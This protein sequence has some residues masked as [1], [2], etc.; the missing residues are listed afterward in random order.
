M[1]TYDL[2]I[3]E[4]RWETIFSDFSFILN[5]VVAAISETLQPDFGKAHLHLEILLTNDATIQELNKEWRG[6]DKPTNVLS[7]PLHPALIKMVPEERKL[8][9]QQRPLWLGDVVVALETLEH[10][11]QTE[12]KAIKDHF[13]HL[14][15]HSI[16]HLLGYDHENDQEAQEMEQLEVIGLQKLG[17]SSPY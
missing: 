14:V 1:L 5:P 7:F 16:L 9:L 3:A 2:D 4:S 10:E 11:A 15:I 17:I 6:K 13:C 8:L 12:G